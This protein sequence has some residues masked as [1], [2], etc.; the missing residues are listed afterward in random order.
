MPD[1]IP[2]GLIRTP[3]GI[4][5]L[6]DDTHLSRWVEN[7]K[8]LDVAEGQIEFYKRFIPVGGTVVDAGASLGDHALTYAK[9]VG[10]SGHVIAVE[11]NPLAFLALNLNFEKWINVLLLPLAL[12]DGS[13][14][15]TFLREANAGA[16][17]AI[18]GDIQTVRCTTIDL[19]CS[20]VQRLD[21]IHLDLE[22]YEFKALYGARKTLSRFRPVIVLE[23]NHACLK[24]NNVT[25]A[26]VLQLL[27]E[28]GYHWEEL[29]PH[30]NSS[31]PQR[32]I[33]A[34]PKT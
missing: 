7:H 33:L 9:L 12:S 13:G 25:E 24:R 2:D 31:Y 17:Y 15:V 23:I 10:P 3:E 29:E 26:H 14:T 16:S 8:R 5:V 11:P 34:L 27:D 32:D 6:R 1:A 4:Y 28:I 19:L 22:G 20:G 30:L 21:F 18:E